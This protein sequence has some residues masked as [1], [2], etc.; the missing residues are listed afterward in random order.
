MK[1][2]ILLLFLILGIVCLS[3]FTKNSNDSIAIDYTVIKVDSIK[4]W[5]LIYVSRNDSIFK[6]A[7]IKNQNCTCERISVGKQYLLE[8]QKRV[9]NVLSKDGLKILPM[10]Y[11]D[12][13]GLSFNQNTDVFMSLEKG[14]FGLYSC[15]NI[16]G[17]CLVQK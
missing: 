1:Q 17:L 2:S 6:I 7:S 13:S 11:S 12:V 4:N 8:L 3:S 10:N 9:E 14:I 16:K 5:Y 15:R